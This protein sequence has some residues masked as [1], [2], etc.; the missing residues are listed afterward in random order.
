MSQL[1][2]QV[3]MII[4]ATFN[5][6]EEEASV[7]ARRMVGL[8]VGWSGEEGAA[9]LAWAHLVNK[10]LGDRFPWKSEAEHQNWLKERKDWYRA[11]DFL[12]GS[13]PQG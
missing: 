4:L 8:A 11:Y 12:Y 6:S 9:Q 3:D 7:E 1:V 13:K 5:I 2:A 10:E